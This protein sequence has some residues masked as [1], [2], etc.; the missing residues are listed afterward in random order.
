MELDCEEVLLLVGIELL[1]DWVEVLVL[2]AAELD[3]E[4]VLVLVR[5]GLLLD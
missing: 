4:E 3:C 2:V 5:T 1:L